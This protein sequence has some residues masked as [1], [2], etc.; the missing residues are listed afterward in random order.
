LHCT[1]R[2]LP[3]FFS[4][5]TASKESAQI[6][7]RAQPCNGPVPPSLVAVV[8]IVGCRRRRRRR[9]RRRHRRAARHAARGHRLVDRPLRPR[10][11]RKR[12]R[13]NPPRLLGASADHEARPRALVAAADAAAALAAAITGAPSVDTRTAI[14]RPPTLPS[15]H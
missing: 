15:I 3:M 2:S 9:R 7:V 10:R 6:G 8:V 13:L 4:A 14:C 5:A 11:R 1:N 12:S